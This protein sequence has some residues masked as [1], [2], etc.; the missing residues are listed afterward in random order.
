MMG[1]PQY[2]AW[3]LARVL[4]N[5]WPSQNWFVNLFRAQRCARCVPSSRSSSSSAP[6]P[7]RSPQRW[8]SMLQRRYLI[9][10]WF[11]LICISLFDEYSKKKTLEIGFVGCWG[12][13]PKDTSP[14]M[15]NLLL[16]NLLLQISA[17]FCRAW[18]STGQNVEAFSPERL[19]NYHAYQYQYQII[20]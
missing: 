13:C 7:W 10:V 12:Q 16:G 2:K 19:T 20:S 15:A 14:K 11:M 18:F 8:Q 4:T 3:Q 5:V 6:L 1:A 9:F 17:A